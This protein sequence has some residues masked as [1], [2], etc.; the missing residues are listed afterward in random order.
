MKKKLARGNQRMRV[1]YSVKGMSCAA[2]VSHVERAAKRVVGETGTVTVSLLTNTVCI[3]TENE[4]NEESLKERLAV[5]MRAA[6]YTLV[7]EEKKKEEGNSEFKK[8]LLRLIVSA[9]FTLVLMY[10]SMGGMMGLPIPSFLSGKENGIWMAL[11]QLLLT[12][13][14]I[15]LNIRFFKNGFSALFHLSPNMDSLIATG[16]GASVVYGGI[17]I[18]TLLLTENHEVIHDLYFES[19]AM[20]LT[21]VSFGKLLEGR[22]KDRAS[23]AIRSLARLSPK[24]AC[25]LRDGNEEFIPTDEVKKGDTVIVRAGEMIP[26]DGEV[27]E[28]NGSTDESALT[29]ESMP[30]DKEIGDCVHAACLLSVG[31]LRV[32]ATGVGEDTALS[33]IIRLLEDAA[34]SRAPIA[35]IADRVSAVFVPVVMGISLLTFAVWMIATHSVADSLRSAIAVLVISCPCALGLATPTAITVGIGRGA[36][37]GILFRSAESLE[38]L[39]GVK[40][41]VFDKTGTVTEGKPVVTDIYTYGKDVEEVLRNASA[42][43][44][45]SSHPLAHAITDG[46]VKLGISE[47][48]QVTD[49]SSPIGIGAMG[50]VNGI[51]C[52]VGKPEKRDTEENKKRSLAGG[53]EK[54][55]IF[56]LKR[57]EASLVG[58][59]ITA[60]ESEGKTAVVVMFDSCAVGVIGIADRIMEDAGIAVEALKNAGVRCLMLTG[61]NERAAAFVAKKTCMDGFYASL[62]PE[63]KERMVSKLS[64]DGSCAMVGDGINDAPALLR[65]D[66]GIAVGA[67]TEVAIDC[68]DVVISDFS[69]MGVADAYLLSRATIRIIKQNLFWALFYNAICIPIAAGVFYPLFSLQLSPM[70]ASAAM[71][72]SSVFVVTNALR[73]RSVKLGKNQKKGENKM[74]KCTLLVEGMMCPRC[75]AHVKKALEEVEGVES[76]DVSLENASATVVCPSSVTEE[77]LISAIVAAGYEAKKK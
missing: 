34:A 77:T 49:F 58:A 46:A 41:V 66:V 35:R 16:A 51:C 44:H 60:L 28:G 43:E 64:E 53:K 57:E 14:V 63:D 2:C 48:P 18:I 9:C 54:N 33:R 1:Q 56:V 52:R 39:C 68:A 24:Y 8:S 45:L 4:V 3:H 61:D 76:V 22:A 27:I 23:D 19:A 17:S 42:V 59:D 38:R 74:K 69:P 55:G 71:S 21:L 65:A 11:S 13:P 62:L 75:V 36:R 7:T 5:A 12:I 20:I 26:V 29:G 70:L 10:I 31:Y 30:V 72:L 32:R 67:G 47:Y 6:G 40:T 73:L 37:R 25:V 15:L 50:N